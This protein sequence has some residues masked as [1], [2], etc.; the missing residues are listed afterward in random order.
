MLI[1]EGNL[2]KKLERYQIGAEKNTFT[3]KPDGNTN[4]HTDRQTDVRKFAFIE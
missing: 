1:Y 4:L 3:T 2:H